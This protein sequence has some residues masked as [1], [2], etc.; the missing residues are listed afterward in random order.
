MMNRNQDSSDCRAAVD[1]PY[2]PVRAE[3]C[4]RE[5]AC[6][7]LSNIG[8][9]N[10]EMSAVSLYLYN[11][12]ILNPEYE[13]V[14]TCFHK[15]SIT[16]MHHLHIFASLAFQM[17]LD[18][19]L[20]SPQNRGGNRYWTPAYDAYPRAIRELIENSIKGEKAAID[21]YKRQSETIRDAN[22]VENLDR[23]ILDEQHHIEIFYATLD[24]LC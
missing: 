23:I 14:A 19:R 22:I 17:G 7:M 20:W 10:S 5:Y 9:S 18:P 2:P 6:A 13:D 4:R 8:S 3:T 24:R 21:K 12:I 1:L 11:S 16:E 15:I